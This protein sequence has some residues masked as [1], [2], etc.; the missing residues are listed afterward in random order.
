[1]ANFVE[2]IGGRKSQH[3]YAYSIV[4]FCI[5]K[6]MPRM[7]TLD[8]TIKFTR[9]KDAMGYC[10]SQDKR[11]FEIEVD[12]RACLK[13]Q[14]RTIAH[15]MVHVKQYARGELGSELSTWYNK[16]YN[17]D[18]VDYWERPWEIEAHGWELGLFINWT[19]R[20]EL[21][22]KTWTTIPLA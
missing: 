1:L 19:I 15:E 11:T 21:N 3:H 7:Q 4:D 14:L 18:K 9:L 22:H 10:L 12:S 6:L 16:S 8:I 5:G 2:V 20:E 13:E 17:T